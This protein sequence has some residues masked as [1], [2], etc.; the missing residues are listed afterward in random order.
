MA[1]KSSFSKGWKYFV[2]REWIKNRP[3]LEFS[4][5]V[6]PGARNSSV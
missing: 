3:V 4:A 1:T 5:F 2:D 6:M